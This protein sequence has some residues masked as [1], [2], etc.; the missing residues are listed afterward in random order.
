MSQGAV[1]VERE[2]LARVDGRSGGERHFAGS[3]DGRDLVCVED[4]LFQLCWLVLE[5]GLCGD[6][7]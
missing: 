5:C 6:R 4:S 1:G 7:A 3:I 2:A